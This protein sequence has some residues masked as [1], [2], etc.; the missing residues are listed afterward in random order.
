MNRVS[1]S[2][3]SASMHVRSAPDISW[4]VG[5]NRLISAENVTTHAQLI[6]EL[7]SLTRLVF[8]FHMMHFIEEIKRMAVTADKTCLYLPL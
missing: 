1:L 6:Q 3:R 4:A 5:N 2:N 8:P 7:S